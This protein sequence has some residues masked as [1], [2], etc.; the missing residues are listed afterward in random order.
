MD[1]KKIAPLAKK[2]HTQWLK[3][4]KDFVELCCK[5]PHQSQCARDFSRAVQWDKLP[6][7]WK[8]HYRRD[9]KMKLLTE[10]KV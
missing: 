8:N 10:Y 1:T 3:E 4:N 9:A 7:F 5:D 6:D 2:L